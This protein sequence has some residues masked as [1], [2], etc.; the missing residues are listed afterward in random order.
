MKKFE[1]K[2]YLLD[3]D[4]VWESSGAQKSGWTGGDTNKPCDL[5]FA[6]ELGEEGFELV[7]VV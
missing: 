2:M 5:K 4:T 1:H 6:N 7:S 3:N